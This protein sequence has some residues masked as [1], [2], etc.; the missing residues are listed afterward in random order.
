MISCRK[1]TTLSSLERDHRLTFVQN[2]QLKTHRMVCKACRNFAKNIDSLGSAMRA[3]REG[4]AEE[5]IGSEAS[6][7]KSDPSEPNS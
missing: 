4:D 5:R 1:A 2:C 3:F 6:A 7:Q